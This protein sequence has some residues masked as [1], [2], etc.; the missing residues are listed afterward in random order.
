M[1]SDDARR[2]LAALLPRT[3]FVDARPSIGSDHP[4]VEDTLA[5][6][7]EKAEDPAPDAEVNPLFFTDSHFLAAERTFQDHLY[8]NWFS[9]AHCAR[10]EKFKEGVEAG[11]LAAPWKDQI[12]ERENG[13][14]VIQLS[15]SCSLPHEGSARAGYVSLVFLCY[16]RYLNTFFLSIA[17]EIKLSVLVK[18]DIIRAG[19]IIAYKRCFTLLDVTVERDAIV[20]QTGLP[21]GM[22]TVTKPTL[23]LVT[24]CLPLFVCRSTKSIQRHMH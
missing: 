12:W 14:P 15:P 19:D 18:N 13:I 10:V 1:L 16:R 5:A 4:S 24:V 22:S 2:R 17:A 6:D 3:A 21:T 9:E 20:S 23:T 8:L 11:T 7:D